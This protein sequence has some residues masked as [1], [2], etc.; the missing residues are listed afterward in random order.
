MAI[1]TIILVRHGQYH[2]ATEKIVEQLTKRG[3]SQ[4][5]WAAQRLKENKIS[6]IIHSSMP[7]AVETATL[8]KQ[9]T[10]FKKRM[11]SCESL[12]ECVPG[13]PKDLRKKY[14]FSDVKM[15]KKHQAQAERAFKKY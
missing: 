5:L 2:P 6:R 11:I 3:R 9:G 8:I 14:G 7:R 13:F 10:G 12:R 15:L 1:R 4:A